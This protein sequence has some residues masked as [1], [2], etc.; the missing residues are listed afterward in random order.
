MIYDEKDN[1]NFDNLN[2]KENYFD[3]ATD[4]NEENDDEKMSTEE[5]EYRKKLD[6]DRADNISKASIS[7]ITISLCSYIFPLINGY[8]DFGIVFEIISLIL[9]INA[10]VYIAKRDELRANCLVSFSIVSIL[11][12]FGYDIFSMFVSAEDGIDLMDNMFVFYI[13]ESLTFAYIVSLFAIKM[14]LRKAINPEIYRESTDW[15]YEKYDGINKNEM[16]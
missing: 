14:Y 12:L 13:F 15:F 3:S 7:M 11:L 6:F 16:K 8:F 9:L 10:R 4:K 1:R 5:M 2:L